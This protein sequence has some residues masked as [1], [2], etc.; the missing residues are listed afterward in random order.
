MCTL[1]FQKPLH[2]MYKYVLN[3]AV[4]ILSMFATYFDYYAII[5]GGRCSVDTV[6]WQRHLIT[7][8]KIV[9]QHPVRDKYLD[10]I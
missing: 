5:M 1:N 7:L 10:V 9:I 6:Y 4:K 8:F 3:L 2:I